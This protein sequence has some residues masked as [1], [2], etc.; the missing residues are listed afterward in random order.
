[1]Q[2]ENSL[3]LIFLLYSYGIYNV[4]PLFFLYIF[5]FGEIQ[6]EPYHNNWLKWQGWGK[7]IHLKIL[8]LARLGNCT[9]DLLPR[10]VCTF[11]CKYL[12]LRSPSLLGFGPFSASSRIRLRRWPVFGVHVHLGTRI[13]TGSDLFKYG[14]V[15]IWSANA[16]DQEARL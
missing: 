3:G 5:S 14:G 1:M 10:N 9:R 4:P 6:A 8:L 11:S 7:I 13:F 12:D 15:R 16:R 2:E